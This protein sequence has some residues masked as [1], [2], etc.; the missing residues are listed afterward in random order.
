M[1][2]SR[3]PVRFYT[4]QYGKSICGLFV[5]SFWD[6]DI[7][8]M[9]TVDVPSKWLVDVWEGSNEPYRGKKFDG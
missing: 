8:L 4:Q 5:V 6:T 9:L 1:L 2:V 7:T 3:P